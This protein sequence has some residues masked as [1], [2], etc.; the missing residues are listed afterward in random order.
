MLYILILIFFLYFIFSFNRTE[1]FGNSYNNKL[2]IPNDFLVK[3]DKYMDFLSDVNS[4]Y[5]TTLFKSVATALCDT[6]VSTATQNAA[7]D[8]AFAKQPYES[9][10]ENIDRAIL[11]TTDPVILQKA[12]DICQHQAA[13]LCTRTDPNMYLTSKNTFFPPRWIGPYKNDT[14]PMN[15]NVGCY[16]KMFNCCKKKF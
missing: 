15:I 4:K 6:K 2:L 3:D 5:K 9:P 11:N 1:N 16:N 13:S 14:L 8:Y 10:Q 12:D 7:L